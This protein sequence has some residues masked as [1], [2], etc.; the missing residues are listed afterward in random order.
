M[1]SSDAGHNGAQNAGGAANLGLDPQARLDYGHL[2][3]N[4][5][6][7]LP[8]A[9][10]AHIAGFQKYLTLATTAGDASTGF[11][12]AERTLVISSV[13]AK[14]DALEGASDGM[15]QD[16]TARQAAFNLARDVP[17]CAGARDGACLTAEQKATIAALFAGATTSNGTRIYASWPFDAGL[18]TGGWGFWKFTVP[19]NLDS[20]AVG[21]IF[22][23]P[24][25]AGAGFVGRVF[26]S[27]GNIDSMVAK[28]AASDATF[29]ES[30]LSFITPPNPT[31]LSRLKG[32]GAKMMVYHG[33]A[34][35]I[36]SSDDTTDWYEALRKANGNDAS[37]FACRRA[38]PGA[39]TAAPVQAL[40][41]HRSAAGSPDTTPPAGA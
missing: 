2:V 10:T 29:T 11:T 3:G 28:I 23:T 17:T 22:Q 1:I 15:V 5:G 40:D 41:G 8:K 35:P 33:T 34:D 37:N 27:T 26:A 36:F 14:C 7:N 16:T 39:G 12:T 30:S 20:V 21:Q 31:D 25:E 38:L 32:R 18:N 24:P 9:A 19:I 13:L 6:F 4:A